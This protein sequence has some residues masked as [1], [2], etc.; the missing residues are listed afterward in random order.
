MATAVLGQT[1]QDGKIVTADALHT[2][3]ATAGFICDHG[4]EFVL[5]VKE[6]R[7]ALFEVLDALPWIRSRSRTQLLTRPRPDHHPHYPGH[8][9]T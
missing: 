6:N 7:K 4:E 5:P 1:G 2:V 8:A 9:S 3:K